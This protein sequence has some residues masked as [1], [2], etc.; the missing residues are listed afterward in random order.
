M[1]IILISGF[2]G[3]GKTRFIKE[4]V[5]RTKKKFA[6]VENEFGSKGI[7]GNE[8]KQSPK[9]EEMKIWELTEGCICCSLNM[10]FT[11]S[12]LTIA[13]AVQPD[14]LLVEPS[15]VALPRNI[16]QQLKKVTY[17]KIQ[18]GVPIT[19][20]DGKNYKQS[21]KEYPS[22]LKN[23]IAV[24]GRLVVSKSENMN[25]EDFRELKEVLAVKEQVALK[26]E[27]Y[28]KWLQKDWESMLEGSLN[29]EEVGEE[30]QFHSI[31]FSPK[32]KEQEELIQLSFSEWKF[33]N[34]DELAYFLRL[35]CGKGFGKIAR[36]KGV[37]KIQGHWLRF[38]LVEGQYAITG[39]EEM[40]EE[41]F[42]IIGKV[43]RKEAIS[44]V[45][46]IK[47]KNKTIKY[48]TNKKK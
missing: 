7:D 39:S 36:A 9:S 4:L 47:N 31:L 33:K 1:K 23:Q 17:E 15:G 24:A 45:F 19:I 29:I 38:D 26:E 30:I 11:Y 27:H 22:Q 32:E 2:L 48:K 16:L 13:N 6:I 20:I 37:G 3:A 25:S 10:D 40:E 43:L 41:S 5:K 46:S 21:L 8:L 28:S 34:L 14:Y 44:E 42:V 18:L 35:L 12:V